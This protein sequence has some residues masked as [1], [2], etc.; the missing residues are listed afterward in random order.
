MIFFV[1]NKKLR[2]SILDN[3]QL[4]L[5][6]QYFELWV[7]IDWQF[8]FKWKQRL[9]NKTHFFGW[10]NNRILSFFVFFRCFL[11]KSSFLVSNQFFF[12][13][14]LE[15]YFLMLKELP[16]KILDQS[17]WL[18]LNSRIQR[19]L[20]YVNTQTSYLNAWEWGRKEL[21]L[22]FFFTLIEPFYT[23]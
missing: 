15:N 3:S 12:F 22:T 8:F 14:I 16:K 23:V 20:H 18:I 9:V 6:K 19:I 17:D 1:S 5:K 7:K 13:N 11:K 10:K 4:M 21:F 2:V